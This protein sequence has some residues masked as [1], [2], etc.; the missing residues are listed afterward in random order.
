MPLLFCRLITELGYT[1]VGS[2]IGVKH[3][4]SQHNT[5]RKLCRNISLL[6]ESCVV[7]NVRSTEN[8]SFLGDYLPSASKLMKPYRLEHKY[9][10]KSK[11]S[12]GHRIDENQTCG[13]TNCQRRAANSKRARM[14]SL[15]FDASSKVIMPLP[16]SFHWF[17][18]DYLIFMI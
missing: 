9:K 12:M 16:V 7:C 4:L 5:P 13:H 11:L 15:T 8:V 2:E 3:G 1:C 6:S 18:K 14:T 10:L 17:N